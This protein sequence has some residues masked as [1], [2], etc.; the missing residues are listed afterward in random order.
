[1]IINKYPSIAFWISV[2]GTDQFDNFRYMVETNLRIEGRDDKSIQTV[3]NEFDH[4]VHVLRYGG[5]TY[6]QFTLSTNTLFTDPFYISLGESRVSEAEFTS[7]QE[8]YKHSGDVFDEKTGLRVLVRNFESTLSKIQCPV[9][10]IFGNLDSQVDW[11]KTKA[12]YKRTIGINSKA[13]LE[14]KTLSNCN[15]NMEEC[16]TGGILE[17]LE[18][19]EGESCDGYYDNMREWL[20]K[21]GF[22]K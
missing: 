15:H 19:Y 7:A 11:Q 9:L 8:Y 12:L 20:T 13:K 1:L 5:E 10:A 16:R 17:N 3:M 2:S 4:Y 14:V 21:Y 22:V 18:K 6:E